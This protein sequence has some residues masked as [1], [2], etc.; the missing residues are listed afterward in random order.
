MNRLKNDLYVF[1]LSKRLQKE[2]H[3]NEGKLETSGDDVFTE[4]GDVS[5]GSGGA[6]VDSDKMVTE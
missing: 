5:K 3:Q 4:T 2:A 6:I 1:K